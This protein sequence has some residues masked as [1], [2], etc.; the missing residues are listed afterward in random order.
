MHWQLAKISKSLQVE[1]IELKRK[2]LKIMPR[3]HLEE[4]QK[5]LHCLD[6]RAAVSAA[7][8]GDRSRDRLVHEVVAEVGEVVR[9]AF[10]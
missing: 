6:W 2:R 3:V 10:G 5:K 9:P 4:L 1:N 7:H 8:G